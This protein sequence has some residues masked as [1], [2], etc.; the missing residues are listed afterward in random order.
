MTADKKLFDKAV[1]LGR[2]VA[3]LHCYGERYV[4]A[5][6]GRP[7]GRDRRLRPWLFR[8]S[9][10]ARDVPVEIAHLVAAPG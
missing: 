3:W 4:D 5:A 6:A 10:D 7:K 2:E 1:E 8:L 9:D